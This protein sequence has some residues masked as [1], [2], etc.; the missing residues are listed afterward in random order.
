ML[1]AVVQNNGKVKT[2]LDVFDFAKWGDKNDPNRINVF[3]NAV[4]INGSFYISI[5]TRHPADKTKDVY[6]S[7]WVPQDSFVKFARRFERFVREAI[8]ENKATFTIATKDKQGK[9][10]SITFNAG[11]NLEGK[12]NS[13]FSYFKIEIHNDTKSGT[14]STGIASSLKP[15]ADTG[16]AFAEELMAVADRLVSILVTKNDGT[17]HDH[18]TM[19]SKNKGD[20]NPSNVAAEAASESTSSY[21]EDYEVF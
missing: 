10:N 14:I 9:D 11:I 13:K 8:K 12:N 1:K 19:V 3:S 6:V 4:L 21:D 16:V 7:F 2:D 17:L 15:F 20:S 18:L 5:N